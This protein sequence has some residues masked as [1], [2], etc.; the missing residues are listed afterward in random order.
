MPG[1]FQRL[2]KGRDSA[3]QDGCAPPLTLRETGVGLRA[4]RPLLHGAWNSPAAAAVQSQSPGTAAPK[5][6]RRSKQAWERLTDPEHFTGVN[7]NRFDPETKK[8][9]GLDGSDRVFEFA[10]VAVVLTG[11][12]HPAKTRP[13]SA[14]TLFRYVPPMQ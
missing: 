3:E 10:G 5:A 7:R 12:R 1:V 13:R 14:H 9:L 8:G 2:A 4:G 6:V 11:P